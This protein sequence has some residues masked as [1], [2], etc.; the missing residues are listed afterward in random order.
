MNFSYGLLFY[1]LFFGR[2][3]KDLPTHTP[4]NHSN[5]RTFSTNRNGRLE[6]TN[7]D[8]A[9]IVYP[10]MLSIRFLILV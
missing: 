10:Q 6:L 7:V 3:H 2:K 1:L 9:S 4:G 5:T 8:G